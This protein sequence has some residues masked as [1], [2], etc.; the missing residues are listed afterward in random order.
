MAFVSTLTAVCVSLFASSLLVA[1]ASAEHHEHPI[2]QYE[3]YEL[4]WND[5]FDVDGLPDP[6]KWRFGPEGYI[7]N[8][9]HQWYQDDNAFVKDGVLIIEARREH[10][11]NPNYVEGSESWKTNRK[12][13]DYTSSLIYTKG[14]HEWKYGRFEIRA[15]VQAD[16]G[17]WPAIW[18]LGSAR[19]WPGC[20]EIDIME[21]YRDH[22]L[23]NAAWSRMADYH[24][25]ANWDAEKIPMAE[26]P[27]PENWDQRYHVWRMDWDYDFIR[28]YIDDF[29]I[30]EVDLS[31]TFNETQDKKNPFREPHYLLLN[32]ALGGD[33]AENPANT[34]TE[35]PA[36]FKVDYVRVYQRTAEKE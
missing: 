14:L 8:N 9:E 23:A 24:W 12:H 27:H 33:K 31:Q 1:G 20:G 25:A 22:V 17:L 4:I 5:E 29:L 10:R 36:Y 2:A 7:R 26:L 11:P 13:I 19:S 34:D 15:K 32:L 18:T 21:Y 30:N 16:D 6:T 28:I 3:G 35:F